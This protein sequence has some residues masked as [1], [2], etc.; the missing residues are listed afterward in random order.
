MRLRLGTRVTLLT[1]ALVA[2]V[3]GLSGVAALKVRRADLEADLARQAREAAD[4]L[5]AALEPLPTDRAA[6]VLAERAWTAREVFSKL[7][8]V[9]GTGIFGEL[10][11]RHVASKDFPD[12]AQTWRA[13]GMTTAA[14]GAGTTETGREAKLRNAIMGGSD[15]C[16]AC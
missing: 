15:K 12:L 16:N 9:T 1:T 7:D 6:Q 3:L 4:A 8:E 5:R 10:Y 14:D 13:L 11:D 2:P